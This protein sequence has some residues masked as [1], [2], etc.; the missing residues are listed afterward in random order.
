MTEIG[1]TPAGQARLQATED[2]ITRA[3]ADRVEHSVT[4]AQRDAPS[5]EVL[6]RTLPRDIAGPSSARPPTAPEP[7]NEIFF[8]DIQDDEAV[9]AS[10]G[11]A[12]G[13]ARE[14]KAG[15]EMDVDFMAQ[16]DVTIFLINQ[17]AGDSRAYA[18]DRRKACRKVISEVF[19]PPRV[20]RYL[21]RFPNEQMVPGFAL[22]LTCTDPSDGKPWNFDLKEKRTRAMMLLRTQRPLFLIGSPP[23]T[24]WSTWQA[25][26]NE[27]H[28][29]DPEV[30]RR[31]QVRAMVHLRFVAQMYQEQVNHGRYFVHE[32]PANATSWPKSCIEAVM[33]LQGVERVNGDQCQYGAS[34]KSGPHKGAP[35][36]K[37]TG[38]MSNAPEVLAR[39]SR[40]CQSRHGS[41][42]SR[43]AG[44]HHAHCEG[45]IAR[46]AAEYPDGLC[47]ALLSGMVAQV[48]ADG[49]LSDGCVG[50]LPEFEDVEAML[51]QSETRS[52]YCSG[53]CR[54]DLTG[55]PLVDELVAEA[56]QKEL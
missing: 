28:M 14:A 34:V 52:N 32:H 45:K 5:P 9:G 17:L 48:K 2:R 22:D 20:T 16:D 43:R 30:V 6:P 38:F 31:E 37:P 27:K 44:G 12:D 19:S 56:R 15:A 26:N 7:E 4:T 10:S 18:R 35:I 8:P 51:Q 40:R 46:E 41:E 49:K 54:D 53:K 50:V 47:R 39:L 42:C 55:Q 36:K 24:A 1:R 11:S 33:K 21:S 29:R 23:C 3:L 25:L 13:A